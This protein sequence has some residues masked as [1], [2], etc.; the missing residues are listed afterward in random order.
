MAKK[1]ESKETIQLDEQIVTDK[2]SQ[3]VEN[4]QEN[5]I[6]DNSVLEENLSLK[7]ENKQLS[8]LLIKLTE[9]NEILKKELANATKKSEVLS[10]SMQTPIISN[11]QNMP[12]IQKFVISD[13]VVCPRK[14]QS[15]KFKVSKYQGYSETEGHLYRLVNHE[16]GIIHEFVPEKFIEISN[17]EGFKNT[18]QQTLH[19]Y[20][21]HI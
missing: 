1:I 11:T 2:Q 20:L 9:E 8:D 21:N 7:D 6:T 14:F 5:I 4:A 3:I 18:P 15:M 10:E 19:S 16:Y 17:M 12:T 13:S